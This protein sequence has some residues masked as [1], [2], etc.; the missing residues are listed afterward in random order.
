MPVPDARQHCDYRQRAA[1]HIPAAP[2]PTAGRHRAIPCRPRPGNPRPPPRN[3]SPPNANPTRQA[4][5]APA[6][7]H[8]GLTQ[9]EQDALY[10]ATYD[11]IVK[12]QMAEANVSQGADGLGAVWGCV[13]G[14]NMV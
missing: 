6:F 12:R 3:R 4:L 14:W 10:E 8:L 1:Q 7:A 13:R 11:T 2:P 5:D 9:P